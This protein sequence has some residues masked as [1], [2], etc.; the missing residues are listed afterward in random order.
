MY[1]TNIEYYYVLG[2]GNRPLKNIRQKSYISEAKTNNKGVIKIC[3][4]FYD[5]KCYRKNK[6]GI[7]DGNCNLR[8][9]SQG[10]VPKRCPLRKD[11]KM[12]RICIKWMCGGKNLPGG[13][14]KNGKG[15]SSMFEDQQ[16][17]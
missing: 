2:V 3:N 11:L 15:Q 8:L 9:G 4:M 10:R 13:G 16:G 12:V 5:H 6:V 17:G 1:S 14:N 7:G